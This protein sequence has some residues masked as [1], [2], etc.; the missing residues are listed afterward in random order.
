MTISLD[1]RQAYEYIRRVLLMK[2]LYERVSATTAALV[3]MLMQVGVVYTAEDW[4]AL[5]LRAYFG[6]IQGEPSSPTL[7]NLYADCFLGG[8]IDVSLLLSV[9]QPATTKTLEE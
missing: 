5:I 4:T 9:C 1:L 7:Y 6:L 8:L 3:A 2:I